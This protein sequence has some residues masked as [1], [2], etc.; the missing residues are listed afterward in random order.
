MSVGNKTKK[1]G[2]LLE[3]SLPNVLLEA[4]QTAIGPRKLGRLTNEQRAAI[5]TA[6]NAAA[7]EIAK[8]LNQH[9]ETGT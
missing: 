5:V 7:T 2:S 1:R 3:F 9:T 6:V 8:T 4:T